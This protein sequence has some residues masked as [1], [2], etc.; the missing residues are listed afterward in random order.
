MSDGYVPSAHAAAAS[1]RQK[2]EDIMPM[3]QA[4][5][6][7]CSEAR[8]MIQAIG[9]VPMVD[10]AAEAIADADAKLVD[11]T[12]AIAIARERCDNLAAYLL[13]GPPQ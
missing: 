8:A 12:N 5:S 7:A 13:G 4:A 3:I 6:E 10:S 1:A 9:A 11:V 2:M